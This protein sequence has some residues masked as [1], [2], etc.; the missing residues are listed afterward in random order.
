MPSEREL[1]LGQP[2]LAA[3]LCAPPLDFKQPEQWNGYIPPYM[4]P[5]HD[6]HVRNDSPRRVHL[7]AIVREALGRRYG[8]DFARQWL[9]EINADRWTGTW[10]PSAEDAMKRAADVLDRSA[11]KYPND[12]TPHSAA[13]RG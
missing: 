6:K 11:P 1:V 7:V 5:G 13:E 8:A 3:R 12:W 10:M 9:A 2:D 4:V